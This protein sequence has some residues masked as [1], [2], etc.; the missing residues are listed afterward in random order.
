MVINGKEKLWCKILEKYAKYALP[1]V[2]ISSRTHIQAEKYPYR[3]CIFSGEYTTR[4]SNFKA[5]APFR[6]QL[7]HGHITGSTSERIHMYGNIILG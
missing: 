3:D 4:R 2:Y 1:D 6:R 5:D 7:P